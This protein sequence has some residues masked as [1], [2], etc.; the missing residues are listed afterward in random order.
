MLVFLARTTRRT[1]TPRS[2]WRS[3]VPQPRFS[4]EPTTAIRAHTLV[5]GG[6]LAVNGSLLSSGVVELNSGAYL[7]GS[8]S[9]GN[10]TVNFASTFDPRLQQRGP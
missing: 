5:N 1:P 8:G 7:T 9:V 4:P 2:A 6:T 10:L 3:A